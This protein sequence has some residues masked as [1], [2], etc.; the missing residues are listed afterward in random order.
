[1]AALAHVPPGRGGLRDLENRF[2]PFSTTI[3]NVR[4]H[5]FAMIPPAPRAHADEVVNMEK[6][7]WAQQD[8][9]HHVGMGRIAQVYGQDGSFGT[10]PSKEAR[11]LL[12]QHDWVEDELGRDTV[13]PLVDWNHN[14]IVDHRR[15]RQ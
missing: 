11:E 13:S 4:A 12:D 8:T 3:E 14:G 10:Q 9:L 7:S 2:L 6:Q 1:M 15:E 5:F